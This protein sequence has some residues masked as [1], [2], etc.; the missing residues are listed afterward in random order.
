MDKQPFVWKVLL[1]TNNVM[2]AHVIVGRL[3]SEGIIAHVYQPPGASAYGITI[4]ALGEVRV[5]VD[6]REFDLAQQI[7][8]AHD[9]ALPDETGDYLYD[10]DDLDDSV[11]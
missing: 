4:G 6:E 2:E 11:Q 1:V 3:N 5:L 8:E 9:E 10:D 7:L